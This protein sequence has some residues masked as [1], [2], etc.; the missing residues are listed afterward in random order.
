MRGAAAAATCVVQ[1]G[2]V[3]ERRGSLSRFHRGIDAIGDGANVYRSARSRFFIGNQRLWHQPPNICRDQSAVG[4]D[5]RWG[6]T[7]AKKQRCIL[8]RRPSHSPLS[9][10]G[11][12]DVYKIGDTS[13]AH[14][15]SSATFVCALSILGLIASRSK[16]ATSR[17]FSAGDPRWDN[18]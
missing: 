2:T 7:E 18:L 11:F 4:M 13:A 17:L 1:A 16:I 10:V 15:R 12:A 5:L 14:G 8:R 6:T 9:A 3:G